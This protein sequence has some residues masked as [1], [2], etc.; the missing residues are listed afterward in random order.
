[1]RGGQVTRKAM[2]MFETV[3][4]MMEGPHEEKEDKAKG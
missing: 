1:M 3:R 2:F 4:M